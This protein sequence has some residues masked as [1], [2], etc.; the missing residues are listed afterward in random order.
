MISYLSVEMYTIVLT[1]TIAV[2]EI[3]VGIVSI[4]CASFKR[5]FR[6]AVALSKK[7][8]VSIKY[9]IL[10][11]EATKFVGGFYS[12]KPKNYYNEIK[13]CYR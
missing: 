5:I 7:L 3:F 6:S 9:I 11:I 1:S 12:E 4:N 10:A 13:A 2:T 8:Q